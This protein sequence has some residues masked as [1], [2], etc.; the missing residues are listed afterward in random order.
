[1]KILS[2]D[3][4]TTKTGFS[5]FE[6]DGLKSYGI[7]RPKRDKNK[8]SLENMFLSIVE[9]IEA[10]KPSIVLIE[11]VYL[12]KG[13]QFNIHTHKILSNLQGMCIAHFV[14]NQIEYEIIHPTVW[15]NRVVGKNKLTK[16]DTQSFLE[17]LCSKHFKEDE[18]DAICIGLYFLYCKKFAPCQ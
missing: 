5:V 10:E 17:N 9:K 13:K 15:K 14:L 18:A 16:K 7:I 2:L 1:M 4:S 3:Q 8:S 12:K 11:D 6:D